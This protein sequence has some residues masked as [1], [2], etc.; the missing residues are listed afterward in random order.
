[1]A[2]DTTSTV[3]VVGAPPLG[4][5]ESLIEQNRD[6]IG[7]IALGVALLWALFADLQRRKRMR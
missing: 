6:L 2:T 1:M 3:E 4:F 5:P 7:A